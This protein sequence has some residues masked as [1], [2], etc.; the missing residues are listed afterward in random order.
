MQPTRVDQWACHR[1]VPGMPVEN[2]PEKRSFRESGPLR[3]QAGP[4]P[5]SIGDRSATHR[6]RESLVKTGDLLEHPDIQR[7]IQGLLTLIHI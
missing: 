1:P 5:N 6:F 7:C 4:H 2:F 3:H